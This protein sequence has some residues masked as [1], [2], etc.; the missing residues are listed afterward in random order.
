M[1]RIISSGMQWAARR[2]PTTPGE[3]GQ[4][5]V[6]VGDKGTCPVCNGDGYVTMDTRLFVCNDC[7]GEGTKTIEPHPNARK[8][9]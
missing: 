4:K 6:H 8:T 1:S 2:V 5:A 3:N 7:H 9:T